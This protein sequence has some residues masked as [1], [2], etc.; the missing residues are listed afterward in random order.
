[1]SFKRERFKSVIK[2]LDVT[3][4]RVLFPVFFQLKICLICQMELQ[5]IFVYHLWVFLPV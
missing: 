3:E 1:M 4:I 2:C 5:L